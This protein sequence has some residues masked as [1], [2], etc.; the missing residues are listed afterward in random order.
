MRCGHQEVALPLG[1]ARLMGRGEGWARGHTLFLHCTL[2]APGEMPGTFVQNLSLRAPLGAGAGQGGSPL[3]PL[4]SSEHPDRALL[5][6]E[7]SP[8]EPPPAPLRSLRLHCSGLLWPPS[9][10]GRQILPR[11]RCVKTGFA[12]RVKLCRA[13]SPAVTCL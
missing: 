8:G 11:R 10:R 13:S 2:L 9:G 6:P 3:S 1:L 7:Q 5:S 12:A 4:S